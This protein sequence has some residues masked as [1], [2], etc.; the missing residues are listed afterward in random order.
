MNKKKILVIEDELALNEAIKTFLELNNFD[1]ITA[2]N[3]ED[4]I[5]LISNVAPVDLIVCDI[6][7]P[8]ITGHDILNFVKSDDRLFY[9]PFIFLS[10]YTDEKDVRKGMNGG[11]TD[12]MTKP[13]SGGELV[14]T[15]TAHLGIA[16]KK[17]K[18]M[19]NDLSK[20][21]L[22]VLN[23]TFMHEFIT[24]LNGIINATYLINSSDSM[25][26]SLDFV[27]TV[28]AIYKS[29]FRM[30]R[31]TRNLLLCSEFLNNKFHPTESFADSSYLSDVFNSVLDYYN[32]G[33][34]YNDGRINSDI[35]F[36]TQ[37]GNNN[38]YLKIIFLELLDNA[39]R[40]D[41]LR[42]P[43]KV[44]L[45]QKD[46]G[47]EFTITNNI[48]SKL[49]FGLDDVAPYRKFHDDLALNGLGIGL[50]ICKQLCARLTY[51]IK[52]TTD[53]KQVTFSISS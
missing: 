6:N 20:K 52:M 42:M 41:A 17:K 19:E 23:D 49:S 47:F 11:A 1:V 36:I 14:K 26:D 22:T 46:N 30:Y 51:N 8:D 3:G 9:I 7:L 18:M 50:Y 29:S 48:N 25:L 31:N 15:I 10:A 12:Y 40:F 4:G 28:S 34:T 35:S 53:R 2:Q 45:K 16:S 27:D 33:I 44:N 38:D 13:F 32:N 39:V 5:R 37:Q 43:P 21:W 24:P